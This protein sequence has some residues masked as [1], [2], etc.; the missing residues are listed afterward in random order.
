MTRDDAI[1][2]V[3]IDCGL[4]IDGIETLVE[5][6]GAAKLPLAEDCPKD[7]NAPNA[8]GNYD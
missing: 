8:R 2:H 4:P 5:L 6:V 3:I 7:S 1:A